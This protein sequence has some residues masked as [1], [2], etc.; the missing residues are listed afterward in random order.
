MP[1]VKDIYSVP[2]GLRAYPN[3]IIRSDSYNSL[4][5][6]LVADNNQPRPVLAGGTGASNALQARINLGTDDASHIIKG[7]LPQICLPFQPVQQSGGI[8]QQNNK[9]FIGW[10]GSRILI[11]VDQKPQGDIWT[12]SLAPKA[13]QT[14]ISLASSK[15]R[16]VYTTTQGTYDTAPLSEFM[17]ILLSTQNMQALQQLL[18]NSGVSLYH[19]NNKIIN[20][21]SD[22]EIHSLGHGKVW[23]TINAVKIIANDALEKNNNFDAT[24]N[25]IRRLA[26]DAL[27]KTSDL[28]K[29]CMK[30]SSVKEIWRENGYINFNTF[31]GNVGCHYFVSDERLKNVHGVSE[32]NALD[33][34]DRMELVTFN[35]L[36][37]SGMDTS[38][39][40]DVGFKAGNLEK[41]DPMM[42]NKVD[43]YLSPNPTVI[44]PYL[45][46]AVQELS[47]EV[48]TLRKHLSEQE[49]KNSLQKE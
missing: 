33:V 5:E 10:D 42:V 39:K 12:S 32:K 41:I 9:I 15:N 28:D 31:I 25:S 35:Y 45:A 8:G 38:L 22:G 1:R 24:I 13:L 2:A 40:Y 36:P 17:R 37:E 3:T 21:G 16:I 29:K 20:F 30:K 49:E 11:Q 7:K 43:D 44:I 34:F 18:L 4:V 48:K 47:A 14:L 6:D 19:G 23:E 46:K 27:E 26:N